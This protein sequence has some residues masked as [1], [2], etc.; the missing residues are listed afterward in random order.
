MIPVTFALAVK[1]LMKEIKLL[2]CVNKISS[3]AENTSHLKFKI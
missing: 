3:Y 2:A 1:E